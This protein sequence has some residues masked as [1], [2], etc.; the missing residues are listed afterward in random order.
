M[1]LWQKFLQLL[2]ADLSKAPL[3]IA[4][5][6]AVYTDLVKLGTDMG[7][8]A[9]FPVT[10]PTVA[11]PAAVSKLEAQVM[12]SDPAKLGDGTILKALEGFLGSPLGQLLLQLLLSK[13]GIGGVTPPV[14]PTA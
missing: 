12:A 8:S 4:D 5:A 3:I 11:K 7:V 13:L 10:P 6:Q 9:L 1:D 2:T 14:T